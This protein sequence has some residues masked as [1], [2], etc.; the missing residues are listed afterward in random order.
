[1]QHDLQLP[2]DVPFG[3]RNLVWGSLSELHGKP[4]KQL[5]IPRISQLDYPLQGGMRKLS[6]LHVH[7]LRLKPRGERERKS[8]QRGRRIKWPCSERAILLRLRLLEV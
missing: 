2:K 8:W 1:M 3:L 5:V 7:T 4:A 6:S